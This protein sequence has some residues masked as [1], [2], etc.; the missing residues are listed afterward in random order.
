MVLKEDFKPLR[1]LFVSSALE[2][3]YGGPPEA[4]VGASCAMAR[5]GCQSKIRIYGQTD[6]SVKR[7]SVFFERLEKAGVHVSLSAASRLSVYGGIGSFCD[8]LDLRR[9]IQEADWISIHGIYK[10]ENLLI[11]ILALLYKTPFSIMPHGT[12]TTYQQKIHKFRKIPINYLLKISILKSA[13]R[14][15]VATEIEKEEL[16]DFL[17]KKALVTGLGIELPH[18]IITQ[19]LPLAKTRFI[20][21]GRLAPKKRVDLAISAFEIFC[22]SNLQNSN[23]LDIYGTGE[24]EYEKYLQHLVNISRYSSQIKLNGW[25]DSAQ[26][27]EIYSTSDCFLLTSEDENFAISVAEALSYGLPCVVSEKVA[28]SKL[29]EKFNAGAVFSN[30]HPKI[31]A[32]SMSTVVNAN[33]GNMKTAALKASV[34]LNWISVSK[35]WEKSIKEALDAP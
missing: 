22:D 9:E 7:N 20:F 27:S 19:E 3:A 5:N 24:I 33:K 29:V 23:R 17:K 30:L 15:F 10:Y 25:L 16:P 11:Y 13:K 31:I 34:E 1:T 18:N 28:L 6:S 12:Y 4:V 26:K 8:F 2:R 21:V 14:V 32:E 35:V